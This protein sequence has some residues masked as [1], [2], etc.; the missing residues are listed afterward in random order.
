MRIQNLM[1]ML[2]FSSSAFAGWVSGGGSL[3]FS[4]NNPWFFLS[5]SNQIDY[6]IKLE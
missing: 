3:D 2:L 4:R 5:P 1:V 6:C